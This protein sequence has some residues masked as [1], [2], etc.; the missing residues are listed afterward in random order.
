MEKCLTM[1]AGQTPVQKYWHKLLGMIEVHPRAWRWRCLPRARR[2]CG[3]RPAVFC[4]SRPGRARPWLLALLG[5]RGSPCLWRCARCGALQL[6]PPTPLLPTSVPAALTQ[7]GTLSP[8]FVITHRP[9]LEQAA[10]AYR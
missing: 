10:E 2:C 5:R 8:T 3:R 9:P 1:R 7:D 4:V 6:L